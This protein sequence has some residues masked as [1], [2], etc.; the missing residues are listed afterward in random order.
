MHLPSNYQN[1][2]D[3]G[4]EYTGV[5]THTFVENPLGKRPSQPHFES[6]LPTGNDRFRRE[7]E[8]ALTIRLDNGKRCSPRKT[9]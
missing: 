4:F 5:L 3:K 6:G 7:T 2:Q 9:S 1:R 8:R